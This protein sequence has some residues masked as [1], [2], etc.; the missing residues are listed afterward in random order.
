MITSRAEDRLHILRAIETA[1][2]QVAS[3]ATEELSLEDIYMKYVGE[4][5]GK[6]R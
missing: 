3:F 2:G 5:D 4:T 6:A 1:G